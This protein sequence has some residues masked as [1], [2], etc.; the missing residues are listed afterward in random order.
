MYKPQS[1]NLHSKIRLMVLL[2]VLKLKKVPGLLILKLNKT[3]VLVYNL[4]SVI[5]D[6]SE[7]L[8]CHN[9]YATRAYRTTRT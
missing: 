2:F 4:F 5:L 3:Q 7:V 6:S 8:E 1:I 9:A